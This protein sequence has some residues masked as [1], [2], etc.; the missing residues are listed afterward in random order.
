MDIQVAEGGKITKLLPDVIIGN[1]GHN[2]LLS[3]R[4]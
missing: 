1:A 3:E 2:F 4:V